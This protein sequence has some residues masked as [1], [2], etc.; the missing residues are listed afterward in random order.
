MLSDDALERTG[1]RKGRGRKKKEKKLEDR[2]SASGFED[3]KEARGGK[4]G[5][6]VGGV[7]RG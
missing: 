6:D 7:W 4:K 1:T 3:A 5:G 2:K